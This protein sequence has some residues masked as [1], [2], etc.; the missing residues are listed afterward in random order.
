MVVQYLELKVTVAVLT[1]PISQKPQQ[2]VAE[3]VQPPTSGKNPPITEQ[4]GLQLQVQ[5]VRLTIQAQL[6]KRHN[7]EE[8]PKEVVVQLI[9]ILI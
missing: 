7:I 8:V 5:Q 1:Q 6:H 2:Q 3:V 9:F 4:L